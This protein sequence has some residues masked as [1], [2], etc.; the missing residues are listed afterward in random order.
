VTNMSEQANQEIIREYA[1]RPRRY[2][3]AGG[4]LELYWGLWMLGMS[5]LA[6]ASRLA[7]KSWRA[8]F[9]V[10][11]VAW[12]VVLW[13]GLKAVRRRFTDRR[14]GYVEYRR[15]PG[16]TPKLLIWAELVGISVVVPALCE[17]FPF[18]RSAAIVGVCNAALYAWFSR[19]D[20]PWKWAILLAMAAG[21]LILQWSGVELRKQ[22]LPWIGLVGALWTIG[23]AITFFLYLRNSKEVS[24]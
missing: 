13:I 18:L 7:P 5:L 11:I 12:Q 15:R 8:A 17:F 21:P 24:E 23:G 6:G 14:T 1:D 4:L 22:P 9:V 16:G 3:N 2:V 20:Q 19:L 10:G